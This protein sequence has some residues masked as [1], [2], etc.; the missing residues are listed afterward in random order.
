[1][2]LQQEPGTFRLLIDNRERHVNTIWMQEQLPG[3]VSVVSEAMDIGDFALQHQV[4]ASGSVTLLMFERKTLPDL[5]SSVID[6]RYKSQ[7]E[8]MLAYLQG[9]AKRG[10]YVLEGFNYA[11]IND[12]EQYSGI[13]GKAL[14]TIFI[15]LQAVYGFSVICTTSA[16]DT[17]NAIVDIVHRVCAKPEKYQL[18]AGGSPASV[19]TDLIK[20]KKCD[21]LD[22]ADKLALVQLCSIPR[23][24]PS[25][26]GEILAS[27]ESASI[28]DF[29]RYVDRDQESA[30]KHICNI[31]VHNRK[32]GKALTDRLFQL[33]GF[34]V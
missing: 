2:A 31:K 15:E 34:K 8:R 33:M 5:C 18:K 32:V 30:Y 6:G 3:T 25:I 7:K 29:V 10:I 11:A 28:A 17:C 13:S 22:G 19:I 21:N 23:M 26:A 1:M 16:R 20:P 24:S 27:T 4:D 14:K 12:W 9:D